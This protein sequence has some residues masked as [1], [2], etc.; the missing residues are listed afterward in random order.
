MD[1]WRGNSSSLKEDCVKNEVERIPIA[2]WK[3]EDNVKTS[4][5]TQEIMEVST[6]IYKTQRKQHKELMNLRA[7][8][9]RR[10]HYAQVAKRK[11]RRPKLTEPETNGNIT[12]DIKE[13]HSIIREYLK[14]CIPFSKE[15]SMNF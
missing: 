2:R 8:S 5:T 6:E 13:I 14:S 4:G 12:T 9:V 7:G 10:W 1:S 3:W 15:K 11:K